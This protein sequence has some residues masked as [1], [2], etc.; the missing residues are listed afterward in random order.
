MRAI[1]PGASPAMRGS[2]DP[3]AEAASPHRSRRSSHRSS[4]CRTAPLRRRRSPASHRRR[5][6]KSNIGEELDASSLKKVGEQ[7][8]SNPGGVFEDD[9]GKKFYVKKGKSK[10]HVRNEMIAAALYDLAGTPTLQYR[11]VKGGTHVATEI[12]KL[13]KDNASKLSKAE[14]SEAARDFA[15]HAWLAN[16]DAVGLGGDNLGTIK[17]VPTALDLGGALEYRAQG[18]RRARRSGRTSPN[19]TRCATRRSTRTRP[20]SSAT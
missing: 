8:G 18:A 19:S 11:P 5:T 2:S 9:A 1:I 20:A 10:E 12:E 4:A 6:A 3:V 16:W 15:V 14:K 17:G 7:M 13:S